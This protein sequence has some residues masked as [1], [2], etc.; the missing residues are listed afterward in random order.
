MKPYTL[1]S[2]F[3]KSTLLFATGLLMAG[4]LVGCNSQTK[5]G[6]EW[7]FVLTAKHGEIAKN[8][9][10]QYVL[11]L[12]YQ[13]MQRALMFSDRPYRLAYEITIKQ[14]KD[15]WRKGADSFKKD[16][17]NAVIVIN[18]QSQLVVLTRINV[19]PNHIQFTLKQD[20][21]YRITGAHGAAAVFI[22]NHRGLGRA[23]MYSYREGAAYGTL[24][25][26]PP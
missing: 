13:H 10:G 12:K 26:V 16:P 5:K 23:L 8:T 7:L 25:I 21:A 4:L 19:S 9:Q 2:I 3:K 14:L 24:A 18:G 15:S 22:D 17:P 6:P 1:K 11:T 20:G